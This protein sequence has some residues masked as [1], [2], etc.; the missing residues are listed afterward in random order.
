MAWTDD[1]QASI[2]SGVN[3]L[4]QF[5]VSPQ[6]PVVAGQL[7]AAAMGPA[8][9]SWQA[10]VGNVAANYGKSK[11]AATEAQAQAAKQSQVN[12]WLKGIL[13]QILSG[14]KMTPDG[15]A[16]PSG[17]TI[18]INPDGTYKTT[19]DGNATTIGGNAPAGAPVGTNSVLKPQAPQLAGQPQ[20]SPTM[21]PGQPAAP[22]QAPQTMPMAPAVNPRAYP[23]Y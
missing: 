17:T 8:Q 19:I 11:I 21:N 22:V 23:F 12:E 2:A 5:L 18:K 15:V 20:T 9:N 7:G 1:A 14:V 10:Q 6:M 3:N 16:G 13:P 4:G